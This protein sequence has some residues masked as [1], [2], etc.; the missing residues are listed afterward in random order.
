MEEELELRCL[1][2]PP[3]TPP[4]YWS[5]VITP[6]K[7]FAACFKIGDSDRPEWRRTFILILFLVDFWLKSYYFYS[8]YKIN[9]RIKN[10]QSIQNSRRSLRARA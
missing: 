4:I 9:N 7:D 6:F 5:G 2:L 3:S 10:E 8:R 1:G